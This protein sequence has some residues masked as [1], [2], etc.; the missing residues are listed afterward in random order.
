MEIATTYALCNTLP[1]NLLANF[2]MAAG[3]WLSHHFSKGIHALSHATRGNYSIPSFAPLPMV[4]I[5]VFP[6]LIRIAGMENNILIIRKG[7]LDHF[8]DAWGAVPVMDGY[9]NILGSGHVTRNVLTFN[10]T[11]YPLIPIQGTSSAYM[12]T[13]D[14]LP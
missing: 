8:G 12:K 14:A 10:G 6:C 13:G 1:Q 11:K 7:E 9:L 4:P 2:V 5:Y 3:F